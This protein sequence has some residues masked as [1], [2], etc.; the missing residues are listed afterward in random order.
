MFRLVYFLIICDTRTTK[1]YPLKI[2]ATNV[3]FEESPMDVGLVSRMISKVDYGALVG[4]ITAIRSTNLLSADLVPEIP[5][6][7]PSA[8]DLQVAEGDTNAVLEALHVIMFNIHV[9]EGALICPDTGRRFPIK[10]G[11]PNMILHEDEI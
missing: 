7:K 1:G 3:I 8:N 10:D 9:L 5:T 6:D 11:I 2:E 4:A